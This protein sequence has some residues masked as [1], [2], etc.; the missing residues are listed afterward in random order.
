M[1]RYLNQQLSPSL[2]LEGPSERHFDL[3]YAARFMARMLPLA[4]VLVLWD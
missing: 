1:V 2:V 3:C 4:M